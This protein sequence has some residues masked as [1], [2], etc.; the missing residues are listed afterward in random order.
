MWKIVWV[1]GLLTEAELILAHQTVV[2]S[3][4]SGTFTDFYNS[5][6]N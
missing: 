2:G 4:C 3:R 6:K 5:E 1:R